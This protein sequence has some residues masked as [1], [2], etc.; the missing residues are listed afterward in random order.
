M[1]KKSDPAYHLKSSLNIRANIADQRRT[2]NTLWGRAHKAAFLQK[3]SS[4]G[5][6]SLQARFASSHAY[7][8]LASGAAKHVADI[9]DQ[10][11]AHLR[12][13]LAE[14]HSRAPAMVT[15]GKGSIT[16]LEQVVAAYV[17]TVVGRA[18]MMRRV[19]KASQKPSRQLVE[20]AARWIN[21]D[22]AASANF[23]PGL[24]AIPKMKPKSS[25]KKGR[26]FVADEAA[27]A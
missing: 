15:L 4:S 1:P 25:G 17:Q 12:S 22:I 5:E 19:T 8:T 26:K 18:E 27:E 16:F 3:K 24:T 6:R 10:D 2:F 21:A 7:K 23:A 9:V 11:A 20:L 13:S 14:E